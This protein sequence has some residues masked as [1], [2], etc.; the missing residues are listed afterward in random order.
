MHFFQYSSTLF[1]AVV[2]TVSGIAIA[3]A[4]PPFDRYTKLDLLIRASLL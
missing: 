2:G 3:G 4:L 1:L